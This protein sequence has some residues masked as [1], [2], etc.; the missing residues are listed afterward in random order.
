MLLLISK[1]GGFMY[2]LIGD[3]HGHYNDLV[4]L[5]ESMGYTKKDDTY[6]H[7][8]RKIIFLGDFIDRGKNQKKVLSLVK[9][10]IKSGAALSVMGNHEYNAI[11]YSMLSKDGSSYLREHSK[12]NTAS[13]Q[14]FLN[15]YQFGSKEYI[16]II[17]WFKTLPVFLELE[18][19]RVVHATWDID[20]ISFLKEKLDDAKLTD[21]FIYK[22]SDKKK[23]EHYHLEKILKGIELKLPEGLLWEDKHNGKIRNTMRFNWFQCNKINSYKKCALSFPKKEILPNYKIKKKP[24][25]Y[26]DEIPVFFGHY[27]LL[28]EPKVQT[29]YAACLDYSVAKNGKLVCYRWNNEK[30]LKNE[31]F[32][33]INS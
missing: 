6:F 29:E 28:G 16:E 11:C 14:Q 19:I 21:N 5:I 30:K 1:Y 2:D 3:I 15:E 26:S 18:G 9:K 32:F 8:E 25:T 31:G 12:E 17:E 13:H 22:S 24:Q 33:F 10:M 27:W 4:E 23:E 7:K 20:S